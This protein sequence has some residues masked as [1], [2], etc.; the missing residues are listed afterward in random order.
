MKID[1][2]HEAT[3]RHGDRLICIDCN[4]VFVTCQLCSGAGGAGLPV[5]HEEPE[6]RSAAQR[7]ARGED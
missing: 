5:W 6:C 4:A 7:F 2:E 1:C 3:E